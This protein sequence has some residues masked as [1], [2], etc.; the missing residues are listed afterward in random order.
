MG[1]LLQAYYKQNQDKGPPS[2]F[3]GWTPQTTL[4][5]AIDNP[6]GTLL[7][8]RTYTQ[9]M[10]SQAGLS[11]MT[12]TAGWYTLRLRADNVPKAQADLTYRL[13]ATY[14]APAG[15]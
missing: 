7:T 8:S 11:G 4:T 6:D 10:A 3:A 5:L 2:P 12:A 9:S 13:T 1:V 15:L 14:T